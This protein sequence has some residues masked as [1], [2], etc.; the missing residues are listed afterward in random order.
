VVRRHL[1]N[2]EADVLTTLRR[3]DP[4][5][6]LTAG[7]LLKAAMVTSGAITKRPDR[8]EA[9]NLVTRIPDPRDRRSVR[10]RTSPDGKPSGTPA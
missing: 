2:S 6:E 10:A 8:M 9:K 4:P 3:S 1:D 7:T 5:Y